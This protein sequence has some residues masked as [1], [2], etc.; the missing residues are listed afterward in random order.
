MGFTRDTLREYLSFVVQDR[1]PE[2]T[3]E[4]MSLGDHLLSSGA[5]DS[6]NVWELKGSLTSPDLRRIS[7]Q[8]L[9]VWMLLWRDI[10]V[11]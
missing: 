7:Y 8:T 6:M 10:C 2:L 1:K 9:L 3:E 5:A 11:R 4:S